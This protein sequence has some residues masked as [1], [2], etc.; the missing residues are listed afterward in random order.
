MHCT[1]LPHFTPPTPELSPAGSGV[2][3]V[4]LSSLCQKKYPGVPTTDWDM[5]L[6]VKVD[7]SS[8]WERREWIDVRRGV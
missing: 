7:L 1:S 2:L 3:S 4:A 5:A 8:F 6:E